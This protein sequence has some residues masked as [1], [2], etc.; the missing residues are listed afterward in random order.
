MSLPD[1]LCNPYVQAVLCSLSVCL[2]RMASLYFWTL[3]FE[4]ELHCLPEFIPIVFG[5]VLTLGLKSLFYVSVPLPGSILICISSS[6]SSSLTR[7]LPL[8]MF[9]LMTPYNTHHLGKD[10]MYITVNISPADYR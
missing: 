8:Q 9:S 2:L 3:E 6:S 10:K 4:P 1:C 5:P 7:S